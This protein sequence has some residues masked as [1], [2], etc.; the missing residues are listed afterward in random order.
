MNA[1][2]TIAAPVPDHI[3]NML[4]HGPSVWL[5]YPQETGVRLS[6]RCDLM[7]FRDRAAVGLM[8]CC[9][10]A[11][12][13]LQEAS[14]LSTLYALANMPT[15][16]LFQMHMAVRSLLDAASSIEACVA[17]ARKSGGSDARG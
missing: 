7:A 13:A 14:R 5:H 9:S 10:D 15:K 2:T 11:A 17:P 4:E 6:L 3:P 16:A 8:R 12:P 1:H